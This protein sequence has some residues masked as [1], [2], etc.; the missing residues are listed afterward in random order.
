MGWGYAIVKFV[1]KMKPGA[2]LALIYSD[3]ALQR[4]IVAGIDFPGGALGGQDRRDGHHLPAERHR[5]D[6]AG[7]P[8][9][10]PQP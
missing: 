9:E 8:G 4:A 1:E 5:R 10:V 7:G 6:G 2:S 3:F